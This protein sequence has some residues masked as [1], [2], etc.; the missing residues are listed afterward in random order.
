MGMSAYLELPAEQRARMR[1]YQRNYWHAHP[2]FR[3]KVRSRVRERRDAGELPPPPNYYAMPGAK[4]RY[5]DNTAKWRAA[6]PE[7][8]RE[9]G[10]RADTKRKV[11]KNAARVVKRL[12]N[13]E[14]HRENERIKAKRFRER[15]PDWARQWALANPER[16]KAV[17]L[18]QKLS[19]K[20]VEHDNRRRMRK[21]NNGVEDCSSRV[22]LL[23]LVPFCNY[24]FGLIPN[25]KVPTIDHVVPLAR[26]GAH[27]PSNLVA[28]CLSCN[29]SK[30]AKLLTE[31][32]GRKQ[33]L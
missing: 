30:G 18:R 2:E 1:E 28:A 31:W 24:C 11:S 15:N 22:R 32:K 13:V 8:A 27:S 19:G 12:A 33:C 16:V 7:K 3:A 29:V 26:G 9:I 5:R 23:R 20:T 14:Q 17:K 4:E 25:G 10:R 21:A 6:N